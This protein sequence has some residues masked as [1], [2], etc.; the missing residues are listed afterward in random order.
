MIEE[1]SSTCDP[2]HSGS[3]FVSRVEDPDLVPYELNLTCAACHDPADMFLGENAVEF[4]FDIPSSTHKFALAEG[5]IDCHMYETP[6]E[7]EPG[8]L[9]IGDHTFAMQS[10]DTLNVVENVAAC[11]SCHGPLTT[12]DDLIAAVDYDGDGTI[13]GV[14]SEVQGM[15][16]NLAL[17]LPPVGV[18]EVVVDEDYTVRQL[19]TAYN[20]FFVVNDGSYG[21]HNTKYAVNLLGYSIGLITGVPWNPEGVP[22]AY[23]LEQNYPNPFNPVTNISF[24]LPKQENVRLDVFDILGKRVATLVNE[25]RAPGA[26]EVLWNGTNDN[27]SS[28]ASGV[29][30]YKIQAG[31]FVLTKKMV[32]LK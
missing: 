12:F 18:D 5:C 19:Q 30:L 21:V 11:A 23:A 7:G 22:L 3:G 16:T 2:C 17:L 6:G 31:T 32:F 20:Y 9:E 29:Y 13:E 10:D 26:Y 1:S 15:L 24:S 14:Q 28:V 25:E 8:Y 27:G 4:G